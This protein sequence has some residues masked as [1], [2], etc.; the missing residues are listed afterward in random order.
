MDAAEKIVELRKIEQEIA[1]HRTAIS[2]LE[3]RRLEV[4]EMREK[5][6]DPHRRIGAEEKRRI[7]GAACSKRKAS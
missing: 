2:A 7:L 4:L 5:R 6:L 1:E 3:R